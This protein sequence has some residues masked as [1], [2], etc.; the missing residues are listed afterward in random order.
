MSVAGAGVLLAGTNERVLMDP[1]YGR[2]E[3]CMRYW[4]TS[5]AL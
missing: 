5:T 4:S 2:R 1:A 3:S